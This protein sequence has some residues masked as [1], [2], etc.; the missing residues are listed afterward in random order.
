MVT[1][2]LKKKK[3][4]LEDKSI[5]SGYSFGYEKSVSGEVVFYDPNKDNL[6]K[7]V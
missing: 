4:I 2:I 5:F 6:V 7:Q 3:V 1:K